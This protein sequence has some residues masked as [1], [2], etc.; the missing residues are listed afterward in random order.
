MR[1]NGKKGIAGNR[2]RKNE[3]R[4]KEGE[5]TGRI[6]ERKNNTRGTAVKRESIKESI[7]G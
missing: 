1:V 4:D 6:R 3:A 2:K 7:G 5:T